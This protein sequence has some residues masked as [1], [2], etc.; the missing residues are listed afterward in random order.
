MK[1][2][3][4]DEYT[5]SEIMH[6]LGSETTLLNDGRYRTAPS[7]LQL[8]I[9]ND[10]E[11]FLEVNT[12]DSHVCELLEAVFY[13]IKAQ[14]TDHI[15]KGSKYVKNSSLDMIYFDSV[16]SFDEMS[17]KLDTWLPKVK[18]GGIVS[19][20]D[21]ARVGGVVSAFQAVSNHCQVNDIVPEACQVNP[22]V[23]WFTK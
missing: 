22:Q 8:V 11:S 19:G 18:G 9:D 5:L 23:Y 6:Y 13:D 17:E 3:V 15:P 14:C 12:D 4:K 21:P 10:I 2:S 16:N 7:M 1:L 20:Y